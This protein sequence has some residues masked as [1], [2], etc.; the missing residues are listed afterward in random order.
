MYKHQGPHWRS[1]DDCRQWP[2]S[3]EIYSEIDLDLGYNPAPPLS[4]RTVDMQRTKVEA[5]VEAI[6]NK[7][8]QEVRN[9]ITVLERGDA[10]PEAQHLDQSERMLLLAELKSIMSVY[11]DTCRIS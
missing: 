1:H 8:C 7:G 2:K 5:C 6:C 4:N 3:G 10:L 11:G 9:D